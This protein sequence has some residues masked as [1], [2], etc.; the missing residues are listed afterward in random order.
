[1]QVSLDR[2]GK[3]YALVTFQQGANFSVSDSFVFGLV[4][5]PFETLGKR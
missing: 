1:M 3:V 5:S 4:V 2:A